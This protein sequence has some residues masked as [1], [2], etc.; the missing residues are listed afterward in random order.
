MGLF[1]ERKTPADILR[2]N[3]RSLTRAIRDLDRERVKLEQQE[4][5]VIADIKKA[6]K[7]NQ[8]VCL[9]QILLHSFYI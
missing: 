1:G 4:K 2:D 8:V 7:A 3:K 6:A 9:S 5:K